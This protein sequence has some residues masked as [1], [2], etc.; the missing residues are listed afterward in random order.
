MLL[1]SRDDNLPLHLRVGQLTW[2]PKLLT[3]ARVVGTNASEASAL[4]SPTRRPIPFV[5]VGW[6]AW[7]GAITVLW[8]VAFV[9]RSAAK[10]ASATQLWKDRWKRIM[11]ERL[12]CACQPC[13]ASSDSHRCLQLSPEVEVCGIGCPFRS[14]LHPIGCYCALIRQ[15]QKKGSC[16]LI[17]RHKKKRWRISKAPE[18]DMGEKNS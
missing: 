18:K 3:L 12:L 2:T 9:Q 14:F 15:V 5:D 13:R 4:A 1:H 10:E 8:K 16:A 11:R 17:G 6:A 7:G